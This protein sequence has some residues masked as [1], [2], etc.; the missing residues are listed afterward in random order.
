MTIKTRKTTAGS[1]PKSV[2]IAIVAEGVMASPSV[3]TGTLVIG[4]AYKNREGTITVRTATGIYDLFTT[5]KVRVGDPRDAADARICDTHNEVHR[6]TSTGYECKSCWLD[7]S[8]N[9][10]KAIRAGEWEPKGQQRAKDAR[11]ERTLAAAAA[12]DLSRE[13]MIGN[14][15]RGAI[16]IED[17]VKGSKAKRH[18]YMRAHMTALVGLHGVSIADAA[19]WAGVEAWEP[20]TWAEYRAAYPRKSEVEVAEVEAA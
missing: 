12:R 10:A 9:R 5:E 17:R 15:V 16:R 13:Q 14:L 7:Y 4:R 3:P 11:L 6:T 2:A 1:L 19:N 18:D 8:R 20:M